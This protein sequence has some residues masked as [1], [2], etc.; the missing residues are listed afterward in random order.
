MAKALL[1]RTFSSA[2]LL[3][4]RSIERRFRALHGELDPHEINEARDHF[5]ETAEF[6]EGTSPAVAEY[7]Y[8]VL[9]FLI[10]TDLVT[11]VPESGAQISSEVDPR[12]VLEDAMRYRLTADL[13]KDDPPGYQALVQ[14]IHLGPSKPAWT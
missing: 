1:G 11:V 3:R 7:V 14:R 12:R 6:A 8:K 10:A 4:V 2:S 5:L 13:P 9:L